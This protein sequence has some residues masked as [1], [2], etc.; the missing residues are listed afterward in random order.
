[1]DWPLLNAS[2]APHRETTCPSDAAPVREA[3]AYGERQSVLSC[4][5]KTIVDDDCQP[6]RPS[7]WHSLPVGGDHLQSLGHKER[8]RINVQWKGKEQQ[9]RTIGPRQQFLLPWLKA[10]ACPKGQRLGFPTVL[11]Q[12]PQKIAAQDSRRTSGSWSSG[13]PR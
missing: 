3:T 5:R 10:K 11:L 2:P 8:Q 1:M 7:I 12:S 13:C 6:L 4:F 9:I